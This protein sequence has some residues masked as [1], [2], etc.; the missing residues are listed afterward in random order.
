MSTVDLAK[1]LKIFAYK[2]YKAYLQAALPRAGTERGLRARLAKKLACQPAYISQVLNGH[3]NFSMEH[4]YSICD[5]LRLDSTETRYF[6]LLVQ[7][8][9][10]GSETYQRHLRSE[11]TAIL[12][13]RETIKERIKVPQALNDEARATYYSNWT[14]AAVHIMCSVPELQ[15]PE[16]IAARLRL[17]FNTVR[18]CLDFLISTGLIV[19]NRGCYQ[20]SSRRIHLGA[21]SPLLAKHHS[22]WRL[23]AMQA[24]EGQG[25]SILHYSSVISL[26][27]KDV[28]AIKD[29]LLR[30]LELQEAVLEASKEEAA[31]CLSLDFF[32]ID[33][34]PNF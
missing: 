9:R 2:D 10:A 20:I 14:F 26:A 31:Y 27:E 33:F 16:A 11:L 29:I 13:A 3:G 6:L 23:R 18:S 19:L 28:S 30:A 7:L 22:N 8:E 32:R 5:F 34:A 1:D 17:P 21:D 4:A 25:E 24:L 15:T 12:N